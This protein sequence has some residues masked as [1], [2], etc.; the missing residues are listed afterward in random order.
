MSRIKVTIK[1]IIV[2]IEGS[3]LDFLCLLTCDSLHWLDINQ[4]MLFD[5]ESKCIKLEETTDS[6]C[7]IHN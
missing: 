7:S 2:L 5:I 4:L 6:C 3:F 1:E